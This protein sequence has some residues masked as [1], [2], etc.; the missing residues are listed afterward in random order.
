MHVNVDCIIYRTYF[1]LAGIQTTHGTA[2]GITP[3]YN[4]GYLPV[5]GQIKE[6]TREIL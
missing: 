5:R 2:K 4:I 3:G 6:A 1:Y